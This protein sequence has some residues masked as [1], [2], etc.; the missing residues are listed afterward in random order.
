MKKTLFKLPLLLVLFY[1]LINIVFSTIY[2]IGFN[3]HLTSSNLTSFQ[4]GKEIITRILIKFF[5]K[6]PNSIVL[7]IVSLILLNKY[8]INKIDRKNIINTFLIAILIT[9]SEIAGRWL[10][11][12]YINEWLVIKQQYSDLDIYFFSLADTLFYIKSYTKVAMSYFLIIILTYFSVRL[13]NHNYIHNDSRLMQTESQK[14]HLGV[15]ISLYN[16]YFITVFFSL[17]WLDKGNIDYSLYNTIGAITILVIFLFAVNLIGYFLLR[18]CFKGVTESLNIRKLIISSLSI[19][20]LN[21]ILSVLIVFICVRGFEFLQIFLQIYYSL[22]Y[23]QTSIFFSWVI[24]IILI[25][26]SS[27]IVRT[28][29]KL[30]FDSK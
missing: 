10:Y 1:W 21:C 4:I 14:L 5:L 6:L 11:Q 24:I 8:S 7:F 3:D 25:I 26:V 20:I 13:L 23:T 9:L 2:F 30:F 28:M 29:T 19:F 12:G 27:L 17:F 16:C 18:R 22:P 15:F